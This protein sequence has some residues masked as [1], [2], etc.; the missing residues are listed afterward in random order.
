M[1][2][3]S[4]RSASRSDQ[5]KEMRG[6]E[7][8]RRERDWVR[9]REFERE[10]NRREGNWK[11]KRKENPPEFDQKTHCYQEFGLNSMIF[12]I[13]KLTRAPAK[14]KSWFQFKNW[15][16]VLFPRQ[17]SLKNDVKMGT[18]LPPLWFWYCL[19]KNSEISRL[20]WFELRLVRG[21]RCGFCCVSTG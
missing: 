8:E 18:S 12:G 3:H 11:K 14:P 15:P 6:W 9:K 16:P 2:I 4:G 13:T 17:D 7:K 1:H 20:G 5:N 19:G 21:S 10:E